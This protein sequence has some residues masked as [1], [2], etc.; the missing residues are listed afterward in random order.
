[1]ITSYKKITFYQ[2]KHTSALSYKKKDNYTTA[3]ENY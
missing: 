2:I 1:M 3:W